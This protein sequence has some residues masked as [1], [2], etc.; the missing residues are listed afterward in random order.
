MPT[1]GEFV[2]ILDFREG[3]E[4]VS[5]AG[6]IKGKHW[7]QNDDSSQLARENKKFIYKVTAKGVGYGCDKNSKAYKILW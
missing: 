5:E 7:R 6:A 2:K 3:N 1:K 4:S